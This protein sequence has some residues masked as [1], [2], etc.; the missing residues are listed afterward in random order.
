[1]NKLLAKMNG[2][3]EEILRMLLRC[4]KSQSDESRVALLETIP[5]L[6]P[7]T[8]GNLEVILWIAACKAGRS[9]VVEALLSLSLQRES[10][11]KGSEDL[12]N[13]WAPSYVSLEP[14]KEHIE[15]PTKFGAM[16]DRTESL[17]RKRPERSWRSIKSNGFVKGA[18]TP[19]ST[20]CARGHL[21]LDFPF[22]GRTVPLEAPWRPPLAHL[23]PTRRFLSRRET[24]QCPGRHAG[25]SGLHSKAV[26][27]RYT[28]ERRK[29]GTAAS[30]LLKDPAASARRPT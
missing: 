1:M 16:M 15:Y 9:D 4:L 26:A 20:A 6:L 12:A 24:N 13:S 14:G 7:E 3:P 19:L 17:A 8:L 28:A 5:R 11:Q 27:E 2:I 22:S 21:A 30:V 23:I 10:D 29:E 25:I 18:H